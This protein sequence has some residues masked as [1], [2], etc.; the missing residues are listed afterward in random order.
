V[1][2]VSGIRWIGSTYFTSYSL[3]NDGGGNEE[4]STDEKGAMEK[5]SQNEHFCTFVGGKFDMIHAFDPISPPYPIG[6]ERPS[7]GHSTF[8]SSCVNVETS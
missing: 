4:R 5:N 2:L 8:L 7:G 1:W 3:E 6:E